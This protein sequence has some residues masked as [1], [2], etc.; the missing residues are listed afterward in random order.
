MTKAASLKKGNIVDINGQP[1]QVRQIEVQTPSAR[2]ANTLY[3]VRLYGV[4]TG[5]KLDQTYK[6]NDVLEER[7]LDRRPVS[8]IFRDASAYTF[9]DAENYEQYTLPEETLAPQKPWLAEGMEGITALLLEGQVIGVELPASVD[10]AITE[11]A[12]G[13]KGATATNRNKP[14]VLENGHTVM[15]PEYMEPGE[16]VRVN[17]ETGRFMTR[18][19]S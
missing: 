5:Q 2:G 18:V 1:Y 14:A 19:K 12:P 13:I 9:M 17:T 3:K 16:V 4:T 7:Q 6:G 10:L 11:T 8:Y 15:V